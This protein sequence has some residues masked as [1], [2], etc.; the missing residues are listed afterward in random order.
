MPGAAAAA[1][2]L[3]VMWVFMYFTQYKTN[4]NG[5]GNKG[6]NVLTLEFKR[7]MPVI[8][9]PVAAGH[10]S[11]Q[12]TSDWKNILKHVSMATLI[13]VVLVL[14]DNWTADIAYFRQS[15]GFAH[16]AHHDIK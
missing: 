8:T 1:A 11:T 16:N 7:P 12:N 14:T 5:G 10:G 13:L 6:V 15:T 9:L 4:L 3:F 2:A